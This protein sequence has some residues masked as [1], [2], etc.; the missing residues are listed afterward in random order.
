MKQLP[1]RLT[2]VSQTA[3]VLKE[4]IRSGAWTKWLPGE[5]ELCAELR[6]SRVTLR[7]ALARLQTEGWVRSGRGRHREIICVPSASKSA[8]SR[9]VVVLMPSPL[10]YTH[11]HPVVVWVDSLREQLAEAGYHLSVHVSRAAF[12]RKPARTLPAL[13][14]RLH[15][16]AWVLLLSTEQIQR[17]FE[18]RAGPCVIAGSRHAG[19][20]LPS[21]DIDYHEACLHAVGQ[22]V[23]KGH[24]RLVFLNLASGAA[25]DIESEAGFQDGVARSSPS[26][27]QG[28]VV[29][30]DGTAPDIVRRIEGLL[31]QPNPPTAFL[32]SWPAHVL[33]TM[34]YLMSR[35]L[36]LPQDVALISRD[37]DALLDHMYPSVTC[38]AINVKLYARK[39]SK[40]V[41]DLL[42]GEVVPATAH[43]IMPR[44]IKGQTSG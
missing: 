10:E 35:G 40:V 1:Q 43:K 34:G 39:L 16:A 18:Q 6:V 17:V 37:S 28:N 8:E 7:G 9:E 30:H 4:E 23:A 22:F 29:R 5:H 26:G 31:R 25:G 11:S 42:R 19:V 44:F 20:N 14:E 38:Y 2:L 3:A 27:V 13:I 24:R 15:P 41:L 32:V 12:S 36:R 21:V 33:T